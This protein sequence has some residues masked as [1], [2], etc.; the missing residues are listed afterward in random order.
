MIWGAMSIF[1]NEK[2]VVVCTRML[3]HEC[4]ENV[5]GWWNKAAY[6]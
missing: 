1:K 4:E 5:E 3:S 6:T 2:F